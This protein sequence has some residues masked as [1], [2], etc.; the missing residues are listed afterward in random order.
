MNLGAQFE[1]QEHRSDPAD[2]SVRRRAIQGRE[3]SR[4]EVFMASAA[5][6]AMLATYQPDVL[7]FHPRWNVED[8]RGHYSCGLT[9]TPGRRR[10]CAAI[11]PAERQHTKQVAPHE[12]AAS[13]W[14]A[15][16]ELTIC[17]YPDEAHRRARGGGE[18][19]AVLMSMRRP[20]ARARL[21]RPSTVAISRG[22]RWRRAQISDG[23]RQCTGPRAVHCSSKEVHLLKQWLQ[24]SMTF[25]PRA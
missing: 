13:V 18:R 2:H 25:V 3:R 17:R 23:H 8:W 5:P 9:S 20:A 10:H 6:D 14:V 12:D 4:T 15:E 11:P 24:V 1:V 21:D 19:T 22:H 7:Q 16:G